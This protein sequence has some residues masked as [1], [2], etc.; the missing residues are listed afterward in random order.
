MGLTN[1]RNPNEEKEKFFTS[2][3]QHYLNVFGKGLPHYMGMHT[4]QGSGFLGHL[5]HKFAVPA[6]SRAAPHII[7]G[8]SDVVDDVSQGRRSLK[9]S[10]KRRGPRTLRRATKSLLQGKGKRKKQTRRK[11]KKRRKTNAKKKPK[12]A[13]SRKRRRKQTRFPLL[14]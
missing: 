1:V 14:M 4:Q 10:I 9:Q 6:F 5:Y 12:S 13:V 3:A 8:I 11:A 7:K 2:P